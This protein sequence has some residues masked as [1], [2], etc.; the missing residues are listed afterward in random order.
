MV[1]AV[2][3]LC[4]CIIYESGRARMKAGELQFFIRLIHEPPCGFKCVTI[5]VYYQPYKAHL[6]KLMFLEVYG[7]PQRMYRRL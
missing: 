4:V 5:V 1:P 2:D 3:S 7:A 6:F